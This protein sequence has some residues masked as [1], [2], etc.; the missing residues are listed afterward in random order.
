[1][2]ILRSQRHNRKLQRGAHAANG[3]TL[4][5]TALEA[6]REALEARLQRIAEQGVPNYFGLQ[7]FGFDGGNVVQARD[8]ATRQEL[9]VQRNLRSRLLSAARSHL[10]NQVLARRVAAGTWNQAQ[11]GDCLLYT[12]RCV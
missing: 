7:R 4:R 6:D 12:S 8:F 9:P 11:I 10:F 2:A 5:L 1:M 3:F